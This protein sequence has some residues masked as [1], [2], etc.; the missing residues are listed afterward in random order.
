M[1]SILQLI[2]EHGLLVVFFN[3]LIEQA[4]APIPAYPILVITGALHEAA[5]YGPLALI[6]VA[7]LGAMIADYLWYLAGRRYGAK[8]LSLL[9]RISLSPDSCIRQTESLYL[10]WG[11]P[12]LMVAKFIPGFASIA[13]VL[14]GAVGTRRR[15]FLLFDSIGAAIWAGSAVYL[16]SLF[17]TAVDELLAVLVSL[18]MVGALLLAIVLAL[19]IAKKWWQRYRFVKALRMDKVSVEELHDMLASDIRPVVVD[20]RS[21]LM[22]SQGR[23]PGAIPLE[24][25]LSH[26][27]CPLS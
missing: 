26:N 3:V 21:P 5:G 23:I 1:E 4:G 18:G 19:F 25:P 13:S 20:V 14:A 10:R 9:C 6:G 24:V 22:Q 7:V 15:S 16:G 2:E 17:S 12:S 11:S 8:L 27:R